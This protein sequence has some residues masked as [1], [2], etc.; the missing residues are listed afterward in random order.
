MAKNRLLITVVI[1]VPLVLA[2]DY[3]SER[4]L[5]VRQV[6]RDALQMMRNYPAPTSLMQTAAQQQPQ[7]QQQTAN[8]Y[9]QQQQSYYPPRRV[10]GVTTYNGGVESQV[11]KK[12]GE[13]ADSQ[14]NY[15]AQISRWFATPTQQDMEKLFHLPADIMHR[16]AADA[17]M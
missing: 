1:L 6:I 16:L 8:Y 13:R 3:P 12:Y 7:R 14:I 17:G 5:D 11:D 10:H 4:I 2:G 9:A 15:P